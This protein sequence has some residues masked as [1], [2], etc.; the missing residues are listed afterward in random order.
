LPSLCERI[1]ARHLH[2][3]P[4]LAGLACRSPRLLAGL[5]PGHY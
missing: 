3:Y 5:R 4:A 2:F 1:A